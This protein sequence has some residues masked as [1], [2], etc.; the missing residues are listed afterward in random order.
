MGG[1]VRLMTIQAGRVVEISSISAVQA[2][3]ILSLSPETSAARKGNCR[4]GV[5]LF[6]RRPKRMVDRMGSNADVP[7]Y[8]GLLVSP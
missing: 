5:A 3:S 4:I 8:P 1:V 6:T 2:A 7:P